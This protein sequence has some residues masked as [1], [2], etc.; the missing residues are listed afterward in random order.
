MADALP[1]SSLRRSVVRTFLLATLGLNIYPC[2]WYARLWRHF[3]GEQDNPLPPV[4][5]LQ[6]GAIISAMFFSLYVYSIIA[7]LV[8]HEKRE[9]IDNLFEYIAILS[10]TYDWVIRV[11]L[12]YS[13]IQLRV[14]VIK[15]LG[16]PYDNF[17]LSNIISTATFHVGVFFFPVTYAQLFINKNND[18]LETINQQKVKLR[19][20][21]GRADANF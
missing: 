1:K 16:M 19:H 7:G 8:H 6:V 18:I 17:T 3:Q 13:G 5:P 2:I 10:K 11:Y 15:R 21:Q 20:D 9:F 14:E 4:W 12:Y